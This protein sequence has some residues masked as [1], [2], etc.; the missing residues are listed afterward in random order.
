MIGVG[1]INTTCLCGSIDFA[2]VKVERPD[3]SLYVTAFRACS[4]CGVMYHAPIRPDPPAPPPYKGPLIRGRDGPAVVVPT[5]LSAEQLAELRAA[6][7][8]ADNSK[9]KGRRG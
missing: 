7:K 1:K 3:G 8:R 6:V 2:Q 4:R 9:P 5:P